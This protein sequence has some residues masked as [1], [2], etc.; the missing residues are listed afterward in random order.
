MNKD[1]QFT[2]QE[3]KDIAK[4]VQKKLLLINDKMRSQ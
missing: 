4:I 3:I 2:K 1:K